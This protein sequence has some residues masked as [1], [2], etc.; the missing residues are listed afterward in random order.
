MHHSRPR[1]GGSR[2][3]PTPAGSWPGTGTPDRRA[4][5][6]P[7]A[8]ALSVGLITPRDRVRADLCALRGG[9]VVRVIAAIATARARWRQCACRTTANGESAVVDL[10]PLVKGLPS[11]FSSPAGTPEPIFVDLLASNTTSDGFATPAARDLA[12]CCSAVAREST[13]RGR[14]AGRRGRTGPAHIVPITPAPGGREWAQ[15]GSSSGP[16]GSPAT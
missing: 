13:A 1:Q 4:R 9:P 14:H 2:S 15:T 8:S 16:V 3:E 10:S 12:G 5:R 7:S 11:Q 6:R